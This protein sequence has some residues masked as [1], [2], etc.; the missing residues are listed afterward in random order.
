MTGGDNP[1]TE[2]LCI[3]DRADEDEKRAPQQAGTSRKAVATDKYHRP[4]NNNRI[5]P[6]KNPQSQVDDPINDLKHK[7]KIEEV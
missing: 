5:L 1:Q 4:P 6:A 7:M 3:P 2:P